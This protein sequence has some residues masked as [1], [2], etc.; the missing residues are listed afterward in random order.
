MCN[1]YLGLVLNK[2]WLRSH[3]DQIFLLGVSHL[4]AR[5]PVLLAGMKDKWNPSA[6]KKQNI[7]TQEE[8]AKK[9]K[10]FIVE[11]NLAHTVLQNLETGDRKH[12]FRILRLAHDTVSAARSSVPQRDEDFEK[13]SWNFYQ[14]AIT[15]S[16]SQ[17]EGWLVLIIQEEPG[18]TKPR[19]PKLI[20]I[21]LEDYYLNSIINI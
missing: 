4:A 8:K 14:R 20:F 10:A 13:R 1:P 7:L 19:T 3:A 17:V 2:I 16:P 18:K 5:I 21:L 15:D 9:F 12:V 6:V 11:K